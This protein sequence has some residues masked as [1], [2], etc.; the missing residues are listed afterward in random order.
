MGKTDD[1]KT[2]ETDAPEKKGNKKLLLILVLVVL[3][4]GGGGAYFMFFRTPSEPAPPEP[5]EVLVLDSVTMNLTDGHYL[6]L[7]LALQATV[8]VTEK[9]D[10]SK[11]LDLA[12]AQFSNKS[13][14]ELSSNAAREEQK[15]ELKEKIAE[16][17]EDEVMDIYLTE[18]V[19]Q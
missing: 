13:V 5:G 8:D 6:K 10:G 16:A 7:K 4:G 19:M 14:A 12:V 11:A 17:Y 3:L 15:K 18:F 1:K 2:A 9:L